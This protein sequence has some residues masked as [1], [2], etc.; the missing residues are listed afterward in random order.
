MKNKITDV[1]NILMQQLD[2]LNELTDLDSNPLSAAQVEQEFKRAKAINET[3]AQITALNQ[4]S[5]DAQKI[6]PPENRT[7][8]ALIG[9]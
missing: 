6:L 2:R 4:L 5:I 9:G 7:V 8:P 1:H 3:A